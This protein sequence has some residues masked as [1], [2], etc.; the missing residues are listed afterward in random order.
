MNIFRWLRQT[1]VVGMLAWMLVTPLAAGVHAMT[2]SSEGTTL[3]RNIPI[4]NEKG[5]DGQE[6][7]G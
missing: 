5:G 3:E 4:T 7:H 6:T 1:T 2:S